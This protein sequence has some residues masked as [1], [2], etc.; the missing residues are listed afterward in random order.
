MRR[1]P[2]KLSVASRRQ[3]AQLLHR[4]CELAVYPGEAHPRST[5]GSCRRSRGARRRTTS[6]LTRTQSYSGPARVSQCSTA[7]SLERACE[8]RKHFVGFWP[9]IVRTRHGKARPEQDGQPA[10]VDP[11]TRRPCSP[12]GMAQAT[13]QP[14]VRHRLRRGRQYGPPAPTP[15]GAPEARGYR[16]FRAL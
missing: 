11:W 1:L 12:E 5:A 7:S 13:W 15:A 8:G 6:S 4:V 16:A 9:H 14:R 3:V 10:N 2:A